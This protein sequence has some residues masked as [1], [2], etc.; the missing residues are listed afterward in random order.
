[1][2]DFS[3]VL[4]IEPHSRSQVLSQMRRIYDGQ[5][6]REFGIDEN[7]EERKWH[8]RFLRIRWNGLAEIEPLNAHYIRTCKTKRICGVLRIACGIP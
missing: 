8:D 3:T 2:P 7:M 1:M 5:L 4:S 6:R